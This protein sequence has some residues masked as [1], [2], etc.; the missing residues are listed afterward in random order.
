MSNA[1]PSPARQIDGLDYIQN[2]GRFETVNGRTDMAFRPLSLIYSENGRGKTTLCAILQSLTSGDPIPILERRRLSATTESKA[3]V[4][5]A[6]ST[7][8]FDGSCWSAAGPPIAIFDDH[9]VDGNVHSGLN[10]DAGHRKGV[11]E[12]VVG[13]QG[14]RLL[15]QVEAITSEISS[16][17][18]ELRMAERKVPAAALGSFSVDDFCALRPVDNI[19]QE[20]QA[21]RRSLSVLRNG[22]TIRSTG[23]F[24]PFALPFFD[25]DELADL[26]GTTLSDVESATLDAVTRHVSGLGAGA[27]DWISRGLHYLDD[28]KECPFCGEGVS[29]SVLISH[30]RAYFSESYAAHKRRIQELRERLASELS[31]LWQKSINR[32]RPE[33][34]GVA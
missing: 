1:I 10:V 33:V 31:S 8:S 30:Y 34:D 20:I 32:S 24:R 12:L 16:L 11:H 6:G 26:L 23:E 13:E 15:R 14:V 28:T 27:E 19:D 7:V 5:I 3:V 22:E 18:A 17:Q 25:E 4:S 9:F 21:A 2:I 29:G